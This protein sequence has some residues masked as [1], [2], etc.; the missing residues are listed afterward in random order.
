MMNDGMM[1]FLITIIAILTTSHILAQTILEGVVKDKESGEVLPFAH[2]YCQDK[3]ATMSN[4]QGEFALVAKPNDVIRITFL[5]HKSISVIASELPKVV[6]L[7]A[8]VQYLPEVVVLPASNLIKDIT[9]K[10]SKA[11]KKWRDERS[12]FFFRQSTFVDDTQRNM[13]EAFFDAR[14]ALTTS[15]IKLITGRIAE[16]GDVFYGADLYRLSQI[17][18][19][20]KDKN[21][22]SYIKTIVPLDLRFDD[23]YETNCRM[24]EYDGQ[25]LY[26][27]HFSSNNKAPFQQIVTGTLYVDAEQLLPVKMQGKIENITVVH[28]SIEGSIFGEELPI[29]I[30]FDISFGIERNFPE[31]TSVI[32]NSKYK[33]RNH[34]YR[35]LSFL[36]NTGRKK[37]DAQM[38]SDYIYDLRKQIKK[39]GFNQDFWNSHETLKRTDLEKML[40]DLQAEEKD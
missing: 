25:T 20:K 12:I 40:N 21:K 19:L 18:L 11:L 32:I 4:S 6:V 3:L 29:D 1:K 16:G 10:T 28:R 17:W 34:D 13:M 15:N 22:P 26:E 30:S 36:Y 23:Y 14:C 9:K 7:K 39:R 35:F 38:K 27:I 8:S 37:L 33:D 24:M 31:V 5:G 2:I